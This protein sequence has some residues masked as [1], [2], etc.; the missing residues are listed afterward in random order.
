M[1][2]LTI[3][4]QWA[5]LYGVLGKLTQSCTDI[6]CVNALVVAV[7]VQLLAALQADQ[8]RLMLQN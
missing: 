7:Q 1:T 2:G 3:D 4:R 5:Y 8:R 6:R